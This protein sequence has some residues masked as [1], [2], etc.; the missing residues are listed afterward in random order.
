[1]NFLTGVLS[2]IIAIFSFGIT[3]YAIKQ[4]YQRL[5]GNNIDV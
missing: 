1:M 4:K 5:R 2:Q 3:F